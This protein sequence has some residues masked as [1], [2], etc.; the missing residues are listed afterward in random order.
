[1]GKGS[2]N[3]AIQMETCLTL[4]GSGHV[5]SMDSVGAALEQPYNLTLSL[6]CG[7]GGISGTTVTTPGFSSM[8]MLSLFAAIPSFAETN[9]LMQSERE[10]IRIARSQ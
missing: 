5:P 7:T 6:C 2:G 4:P 3:L 9:S 10:G 1:M 8:F